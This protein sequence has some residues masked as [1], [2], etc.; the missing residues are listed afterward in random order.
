MIILKELIFI[1]NDGADLRIDTPPPEVAIGIAPSDLEARPIP[2]HNGRRIRKTGDT[3]IWL[4][5]RGQRRLIPNPQTFNNLFGNWSNSEVLDLESIERGP[6]I[7]S[8]A[9]L[10]RA[11]GNAGVW[12][13]DQGRKRLVANS[14]TMGKY[15]FD[16]RK[17]V[18]LP[19]HVLE[20]IQSGDMIG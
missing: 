14:N 17:V 18:S 15:N 16:W 2:E 20:C 8:G 6:D 11:A 3:A 13:L 7:T 1:E 9:V 5:D 12:L 10:C 4:I 19:P